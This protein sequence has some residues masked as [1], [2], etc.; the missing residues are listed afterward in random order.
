MNAEAYHY[1]GECIAKAE[2]LGHPE[3][4]TINQKQVNLDSSLLP[5]PLPVQQLSNQES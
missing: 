3:I 2:E 5:Y 4:I 1:D